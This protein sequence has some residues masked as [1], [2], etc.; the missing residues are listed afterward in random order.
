VQMSRTHPQAA[1]FLM[2]TRFWELGA[3]CLVFLASRHFA[4]PRLEPLARKVFPALLF[5]V[6]VGCLFLPQRLGL[7]ATVLAVTATALLIGLVRPQTPVHT[8]LTTG[9]LVRIGA[10]SYSLYLWHWTVLC[11]SR[12]TIDIRWWTAPFQLALMFALAGASYRY[13]ENPLRSAGWSKSAG[14]SIGYGVAAS[15]LATGLV[16]TLRTHHAAVL[17]PGRV[18]LLIS[19]AFLPLKTSGMPFDPT[20][21]VDDDRRPLTDKTFDLCTVA[22]TRPDGQTIWA[23]GDSNAGHLQGLLYAVHDLTGV[24]V[25]L[26]ETPGRPFPLR[27]DQQFAPRDTIYDTVRARLKPGDIVLISRKF[28][29]A[30]G[31]VPD[32]VFTWID[33]LAPLARQVSASGAS[34]LVVGPI[35]TFRFENIA[36]CLSAMRSHADC[37]VERRPLAMEAGKVH[38]RLAAVAAA[39][40]NM[41]VFDQFSLLCPPADRTCSPYQGDRFLFRDRNHLNARGSASLAEPFVGFL[42]NRHLLAAHQADSGLRRPA[43]PLAAGPD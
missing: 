4:G 1:Y 39:Q 37:N 2:P 41:Q 8:L 32:E 30:D 17:A 38:Q 5:A 9:I 20:C 22:P 26:I 6:L 34:L 3:G 15:L 31:E 42:R 14:R 21:V 18:D 16:A 40:P 43:R 11:I 36:L 12:W 7:P 13:L 25:H 28:V 27:A 35:P 33:A 10:I 23:L 24:G 29:L 19:A